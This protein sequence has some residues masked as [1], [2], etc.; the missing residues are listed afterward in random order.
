M[1]KYKGRIK[2]DKMKEN[3]I[4][5]IEGHDKVIFVSGKS[6]EELLKKISA[7][8]NIICALVNNEIVELKDRKSVV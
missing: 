7:P 1:I 8:S 3:I 4:I 6:I 5:D 2:G